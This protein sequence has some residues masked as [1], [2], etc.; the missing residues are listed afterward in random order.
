M[1]PVVLDEV[2]PDRSPQ[3]MPLTVDQYARMIETGIIP[4]DKPVELIEGVVVWKDRSAP[5]EDRMGQSLRHILLVKRLVKIL[6]A[7]V[8]SKRCHLSNQSEVRLTPVNAP[9][10][11]VAVLRGTEEDY[12]ARY[13]GP[14]DII[15]TIEVS[16]NSLRTDRKTKQQL[17]SKVGIPVY[18]IVNIPDAQIEVYEQPDQERGRYARR[19]D[20]R[21]GQTIR[22]SIDSEHLDINVSDILA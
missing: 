1:S 15:V 6:T 8:E 21:T 20:Y 17:Y 9:E 14:G 5:G 3:I 13:A 7:W 4:E 16:D 2:S 22:L 11:D 19:T 18:W 10:P 12:E